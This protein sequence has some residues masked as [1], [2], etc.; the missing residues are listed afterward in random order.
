MH[1]IK[2]V[3]GCLL[4]CSSGAFLAL[5]LMVGAASALSPEPP[6]WGK[7]VPVVLL[8]ALIVAVPLTGAALLGAW[9]AARRGATVR[10]WWAAAWG[11]GFGALG[12]ATGLGAWT[13]A[14]GYN[15]SVRF[16]DL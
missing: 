16:G 5:F 8:A 7:V 15:G 14:F 9:W 4:A 13:G 2:I 10:W 12:A 11:G 3:R 1:A 6:D